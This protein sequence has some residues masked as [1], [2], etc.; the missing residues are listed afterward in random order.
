M[1][2][3]HAA[4]VSGVARNT[5]QRYESGDHVPPADKFFW[6]LHCYGYDEAPVAGEA[7]DARRELP[8]G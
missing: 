1:S 2:K 3:A 4:K 5:L 8:L 7:R 6:L